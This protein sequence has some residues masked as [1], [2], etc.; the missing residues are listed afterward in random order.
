MSDHSPLLNAPD[1]VDY[2]YKRYIQRLA[3][4]ERDP[5]RDVNLSASKWKLG[6]LYLLRVI[7]SDV[8]LE[9]KEMLASLQDKSAFQKAKKHIKNNTLLERVL[10]AL[11]GSQHHL[12]NTH[13]MILLEEKGV[14]QAF[15]FFASLRDQLE[16]MVHYSPSA[17]DVDEE[18]VD[19]G[20]DSEVKELKDVDVAGPTYTY[21]LL[22]PT[23]TENPT[24][25]TRGAAKRENDE[26][27]RI[28]LE[29][30]ERAQRERADQEEKERS[31]ETIGND[32]DHLDFFGDIDFEGPSISSVISND[33]ETEKE[34]EKDEFVTTKMVDVFI[35]LIFTLFYRC[36]NDASIRLSKNGKLM[37]INPNSRQSYRHFSLNQRMYK[38][39]T[40]FGDFNSKTDGGVYEARWEEGKCRRPDDPDAVPN[41]VDMEAKAAGI[42]QPLP[43]HVAELIAHIYTRLRLLYQSDDRKLGKF[44]AYSILNAAQRTAYLFCFHQ[45]NFRVVWATFTP[46][47]LAFLFGAP[48]Q[49]FMARDSKSTQKQPMSLNEEEEPVLNL[50]VSEEMP[51]IFVGSRRKAALAIIALGLY[52][53]NYGEIA[54][55]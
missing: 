9:G 45:T 1:G 46:E 27:E 6:H 23:A 35:T 19:V 55:S 32:A 40:A 33:E 43:Q 37:E 34:R 17:H 21:T 2:H 54:R 30:R 44:K 47:Y 13:I 50:F 5:P 14:P 29:E 31:K 38:V 15:S 24:M 11:K 16:P 28:M 12:P 51:M 4:T 7:I 10:S 8:K 25:T 26:R 52:N 18:N 53:Q 20:D 48:A 22:P 41:I 3:E 42:S 49:A 39:Q 36:R